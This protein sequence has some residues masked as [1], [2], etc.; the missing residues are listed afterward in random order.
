[1]VNPMSVDEIV[2]AIK[3]LRV[4]HFCQAQ[5]EHSIP[6]IRY[7]PEL[8]IV[9]L[10]GKEVKLTDLEKKLMR[11]L[12]EAGKPCTIDEISKGVWGETGKTVRA[13]IYK[14]RGKIEPKP[15]QPQ[16]IVTVKGKEY[17][18]KNVIYL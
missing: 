4:H 6:Q 2:E 11:Y 18:L 14:L 8:G 5:D 13:T 16:Y 12:Q 17:A 9:H 10:E 3:D 1:M 15:S 7:N